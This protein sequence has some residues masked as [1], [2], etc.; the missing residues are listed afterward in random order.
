M[1]FQMCDVAKPLASAYRICEKGNRIVMDLDEGASYIENKNTKQKVNLRWEGRV[2]ILD[3]WV[4]KEEEN[5][6]AFTRQR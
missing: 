6:A 2:P 1:K 5:D 4:D 3:I